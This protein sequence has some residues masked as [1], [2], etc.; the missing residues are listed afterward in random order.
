MLPNPNNSGSEQG[1]EETKDLERQQP[2][3][4][5][6]PRTLVIIGAAVIIAGIVILIIVL[7]RT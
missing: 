7:T 2:G 4:S 1:E 5:L 6:G 3:G